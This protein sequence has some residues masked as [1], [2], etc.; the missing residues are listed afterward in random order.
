VNTGDS[1]LYTRS[2]ALEQQ[3]NPPV[4]DGWR[5]SKKNA[6][7]R[8]AFGGANKSQGGEMDVL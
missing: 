7:N 5:R 4:V 8:P 3:P 2:V 6:E 1:K